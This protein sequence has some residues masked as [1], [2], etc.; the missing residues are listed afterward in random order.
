MGV[1]RLESGDR[2]GARAE[3][4]AFVQ[5]YPSGED[6]ERARQYLA[7]L[8]ATEVVP[9][10]RKSGEPQSVISGS[11]STF[12]YGG[13]SQSRSQ[14]FVDSPLGG[15]PVL[16]SQSELSA[17][18]QRQMQSNLDFNWRYRDA[19][20]DRR[21][22]LRNAYTADYMP[23]R[24]N[25][26]RL[27]ALYFDER[28]LKE[29]SSYRVGRQSPTGGGVL[30]RFDGAQGAYTFAP[31]WRV[32]AVLGQ[33][34]DALLDTRR[35][36]YGAWLDADSL[37]EHLSGSWYV[38]RQMID[39]EVDRQALGTELRFFQDG[40]AVS[41]QLDYDQ[42]LRG[43]NIASLQGSWQTPES[44]VFN[45][46]LDRRATPVR[47]LGNALFSKTPRSRHRPEPSRTCWELLP[48]TC[49]AIGLTA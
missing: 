27:S 11:F 22:V 15:L 20:V 12:Y 19:D 46:L 48:L 25:K 21:L 17:T 34:T 26:N 23:N 29:G 7:N 16:Q 9:E 1:V 39:G 33:P 38:N 44:T 14:D 37:T 28:N 13:Q 4:E 3:F 36:F 2:A 42:M 40:V 43:L 24:P 41:A 31:K 8:P 35:H 45:F 6:S 10:S 30:Y 18:D 47:S 32:N 49:C 5:A